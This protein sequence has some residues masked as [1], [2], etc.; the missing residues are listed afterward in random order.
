MDF[1]PFILAAIS[2]ILVKIVD[3]FDDD[4]KS[5]NLIK[6]LFSIAY[7]LVIGY[8]IG[9]APFSLLFLAVLIA[10]LFAKKVDTTAHKVGFL[11]AVL[12][13]FSF[14]P[15]ALD[16]GVLGLFGYFMLLGVLDELE[17]EIIQPIASKRLF[18]KI[19]LIP[20]AFLGMWQ[21][22]AAI[23]LFDGGYELV[24]FFYTYL[25]KTK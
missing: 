5:K 10:Q 14:P 21:Y 19:G 2:G 20:L 8:I 13:M 23:L 17:F 18:L 24:R 1:F 25:K 16:L 7:G 6:Y 4:L 9:V 12:T 22:L 11:I 15:P 3:I